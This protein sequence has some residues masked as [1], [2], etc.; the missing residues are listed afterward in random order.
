MGEI[1]RKQ[2]GAVGVESGCT[3]GEAE[4]KGVLIGRFKYSSLLYWCIPPFVV[5]RKHLIVLVLPL[6]S[7]Y[8]A[9]FKTGRKRRHLGYCY[10][11]SV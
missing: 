4:R 5:A 2:E 10:L 8:A 6:V 3:T 11:R 9:Y 7:L 1:E